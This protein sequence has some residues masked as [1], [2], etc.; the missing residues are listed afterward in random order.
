[1]SIYSLARRT[2]NG[3]DAE[4]C[5]EIRTLPTHKAKIMEIGLFLASETASTFGLGRPADIG[6]TPT[7]PVTVLPEDPASGVGHVTIA[8]AWGTGPTIPVQFFRRISLPATIGVGVIWTWPRGLTIPIS[9]S[10]VLWNIGT[11]G[12]IDIYVSLD[13]IL[14]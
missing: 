4:A 8:L 7:S 10:I 2:T 13:E 1:M 5:W 14:V 6:I 3:T 11:T 12:L 9:D